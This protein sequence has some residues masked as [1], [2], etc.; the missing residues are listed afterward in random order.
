MQ[1][2]CQQLKHQGVGTHGFYTEEVRER[3]GGGRKGP[4]IGFD[5]VSLD[6]QRSILAR[7]AR[8]VEDKD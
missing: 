4:R 5:V 8:S 7:V 6:G 3:G 2:V 1:S